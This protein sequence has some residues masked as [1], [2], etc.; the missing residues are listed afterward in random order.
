[1]GDANP[2]TVEE[3]AEFLREM[4]KL[5]LW[6]LWRWRRLHPE[7]SFQTAIRSRVDIFRKTDLNK[8]LSKNTYSAGDFTLPEWLAFEARAERLCGETA[9]AELFERRAWEEVFRPAVEARVERDF[10]EG[11]GLDDFQC[12]S[13]RYT[14]PKPGQTRIGFHI[15]NRVSP[16]SLF[17]DPAYLPACFLQLMDETERLGATELST[18]TWLNSFPKWLALFPKDWHDRLTPCPIEISWSLGHWGQF[19]NARGTFNVR[20]GQLMRRSGALPFQN[21]SSWCGF[22]SMRAHLRHSPE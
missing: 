4:V 2:K 10:S 18:G 6:F 1:M 20:H 13:L 7:E 12:G 8:G 17:A 11:D 15:G 3:H 19:V 9:S 16:R 22:A 21:R 14:I 5:Q